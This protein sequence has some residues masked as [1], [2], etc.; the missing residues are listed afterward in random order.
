MSGGQQ[1]QQT[2]HVTVVG[3]QSL[4]QVGNRSDFPWI[5]RLLSVVG[6]GRGHDQGV[7]RLGLLLV[8]RPVGALA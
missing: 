7:L 3:V 4:G 8:A 1:P 5:V 6:P 2:A